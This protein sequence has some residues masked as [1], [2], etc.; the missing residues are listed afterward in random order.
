[1]KIARTPDGKPIEQGSVEWM[2]ARS[3]LPT[4][5]EFD[6]LVTPEF[7]IRTG[8]MP[9][10]YLH[11]KVAEAWQGGPLIGFNVFDVEQGQILESEAKPWYSLEYGEEITP[12]GFITTDDGRI[13][14]SPDGL[15]GENSG[16]EIKCPAVHTHCGYVLK[17]SLPKEYAAQVFGSMFVTGRPY[18]N[19]LSYRRHFPPLMLTVHRDEEIMK[20][21]A[22]ALAEFLADFDAAMKRLEE[23]NHGPPRRK[24]LQYVK[25]EPEFVSEMPS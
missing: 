3:G 15:L 9:K 18:W 16:I 20:T 19:F 11:K 2:L 21:L 23:I 8:E 24:P 5:S 10:T 6:S 14:C 22:I 17:G 12:V 7:K 4:A 1:M 13:G 25:P